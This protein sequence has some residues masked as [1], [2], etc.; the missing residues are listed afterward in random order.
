MNPA[1]L[2][3]TPISTSQIDLTWALN[4][5]NNNVLIATSPTTTFGVPADG[6]GYTAGNTL[7][8]GGTVVYVGNLVNFN[9][10][11]LTAGATYCYKIWSVNG[12]NQYSAGLP[13]VCANTFSH[14]WT[15][16]VNTDWFNTGNWGPGT[17]PTATDGALHSHR[18]NQLSAHQRGWSNLL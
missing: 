9:H 8:G 4:A 6:T 15:G 3:V 7:P 2:A 13:P 12:S 14:N 11:G 1:N 16:N 18:T 5:A 10:T 17:L